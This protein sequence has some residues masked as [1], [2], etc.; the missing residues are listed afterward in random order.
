M[1][2]TKQN[3]QMCEKAEEIQRQRNEIGSLKEAVG[4]YPAGRYKLMEVGDVFYTD[5][6]GIYTSFGIAHTKSVW[7]PRQDQLQEM[8]GGRKMLGAF[9]WWV[10]HTEKRE[11]GKAIV[12]NEYS[13]LFTSM[14]QLWLCYVMFE[15]YKKQWDGKEW[16]KSN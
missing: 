12:A 1:D 13:E 8:V 6:C 4:E 10:Y 9:T 16:I 14:E 2:I 5:S 11:R 7:L 3:I 15:L